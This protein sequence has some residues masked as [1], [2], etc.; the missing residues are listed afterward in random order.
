MHCEVS[1]VIDT[2]LEK[3]HVRIETPIVQVYTGDGKGKTTAALGIGFRAAGHGF[4]VKVIQFLKGSIY[5]GENIAVLQYEP[6]FE[7]KHF[8]RE[9]PNALSI[10]MGW[11]KCN[12]CGACFIKKGEVTQE[13]KDMARA[14]CDEVR[15]H[16]I[17]KD[18]DMIILDE[19]S[20]AIYFGALELCEAIDLVK[21]RPSEIELILTGRNMPIE[22]IELADLVTEMK[23]I[24]HPFD[25]GILARR[26]VEY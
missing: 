13:D 21:S 18:A 1:L 14:A 20:N 6:F 22:I 26:G 3:E 7:L 4:Y 24:K 16:F 19:I 11:S 25:K 23:M 17:A 12:G 8:G 10:A 9:C 5:S 15:E 2:H